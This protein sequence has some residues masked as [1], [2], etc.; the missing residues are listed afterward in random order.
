VKHVVFETLVK[1]VVVEEQG[2]RRISKSCD[3]R[4]R[5]SLGGA[6]R[7]MLNTSSF[8]LERCC[9]VVYRVFG[10]VLEEFSR[11]ADIDAF[12]MIVITNVVKVE[13]FCM[14]KKLLKVL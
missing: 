9:E 3:F 6:R 11:C 1:K 12:G 13:A 7:S 5:F 14:S 8:H 4:L 10:M 2:E